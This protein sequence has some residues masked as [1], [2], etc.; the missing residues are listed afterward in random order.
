MSLTLFC[1]HYN[2][3]IYYYLS[4][5]LSLTLSLSLSL[6]L[7][8]QV[9]VCKDGDGKIGMRVKAI[10]KGVF[11]CLVKKNSPAAMAGE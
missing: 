2:Y 7:S 8:L 11:V 4:L 9:T 5:S 3:C 1:H 10:N 6:S